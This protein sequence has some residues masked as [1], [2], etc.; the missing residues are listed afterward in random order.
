M[1]LVLRYIGPI[2]VGVNGATHSFLAYTG[3]IFDDPTCRQ[4]A[5]H[6]LLITGYGQEVAESG[7]VKKFWYARNSWGVGWGGKSFSDLKSFQNS[8]LTCIPHRVCS[9]SRLQK[10]VM[11]G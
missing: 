1:E 11:F 10:E 4:G 5:N 8:T 6:A 2:A 3:G 7:K 9:L